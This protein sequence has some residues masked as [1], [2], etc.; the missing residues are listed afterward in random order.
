MRCVENFTRERPHDRGG[1]SIRLIA[2][3]LPKAFMNG[4]GWAA[5][6]L[7]RASLEFVL[8]GHHCLLNAI[9]LPYALH[10]NWNAIKPHMDRLAR[11]LNLVEPDLMLS[12][13]GSVTPQKSECAT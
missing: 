1:P 11:T 10:A 4:S 2:Q 7:W 12:K 6:M 5:F 13:A 9:F 3:H 8:G